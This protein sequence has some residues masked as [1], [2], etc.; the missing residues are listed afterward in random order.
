MIIQLSKD[1]LEILEDALECV[2]QEYRL[3]EKGNTLYLKIQNLRLRA[4]LKT[5][6]KS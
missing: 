1:E 3:T 5:L 6:D 4:E 2:D